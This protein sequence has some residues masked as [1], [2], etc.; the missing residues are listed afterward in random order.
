M[1]FVFTMVCQATSLILHRVWHTI[2]L[3]QF[4]LFNGFAT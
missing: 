4:S 2:G 3:I 1:I